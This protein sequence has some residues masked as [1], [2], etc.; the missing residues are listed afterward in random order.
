MLYLDI[1]SK[2]YVDRVPF[3]GITNNR[4]I[5]YIR[6][7]YIFN[8]DAI[9]A[10]YQERNF[11]VKNTHLISRMIEHFP[12]YLN[13]DVYS[14]LESVE[15]SLLY[16]GKHF[17][18][19]SDIEKGVMHPPY[20]FGNEGD[21]IILAGFGRFDAIDLARN[22]KTASCLSILKHPRVDSKLLIPLGRDDGAKSGVSSIYIDIAKLAIKYR[23]FMRANADLGEGGI[24]LNKNNFVI[25]YVLPTCM[26]DVI[27]HTLYNK[28][29]EGFY[30][31]STEVVPTK[32]HPFKIF[33]PSLQLSRYVQNTLD[34]ITSKPMDFVQMLRHIQLVFAQDA[35]K[36]MYLPEFYGSRQLMPAIVASRLDTMV[37]LM[38][39]C[40]SK[41]MNRKY[42]TDW[43]LFATRLN[44]NSSLSDFYPYEVEKDIKEKLQRLM[45]S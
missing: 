38:D 24:L 35:S 20:F 40:K 12:T 22:W 42:L 19:S 9:A 1:F 44:S 29:V 6:R 8:R 34:I 4:D 16:L 36:L 5:D 7:L 43:K 2:D 30:K 23:E 31:T 15:G 39:A 26:S 13:S 10:Y 11:S 28:V 45:Q 3:T 37:F 33:E 41:D 21:E 25:K 32:K 14:Y 18:L 27:D 17:K